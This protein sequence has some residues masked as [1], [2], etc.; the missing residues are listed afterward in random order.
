[1]AG[2]CSWWRAGA[3][4]ISARTPA[5]DVR[6]A[7]GAA[8]A[9]RPGFGA[10]HGRPSQAPRS[11]TVRGHGAADMLARKP[12][13]EDTSMAVGIRLKFAGGTQEQYQ[14]VHDT[15]NA[16]SPLGR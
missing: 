4:S 2:F 10:V 9:A 7:R 13:G 11:A 15:V 1:G 6:C 14:A 5:L 16:S 12:R 3:S 8:C